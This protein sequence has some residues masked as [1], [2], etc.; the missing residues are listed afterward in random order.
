MFTRPL[1][2]ERPEIKLSR[3][4]GNCQEI[5]QRISI[6]WLWRY[7]NLPGD[8]KPGGRCLSPF[9]VDNNPDFW[10]SRDGTRFFDHGQPDHR[11]DCINFEVLASGCT[12]RDAIRKLRELANLPANQYRQQI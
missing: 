3:P 2:A 1:N 6:Q 5:K 9:Y 12:C 7:H 8:P 4:I 10:I 11:G